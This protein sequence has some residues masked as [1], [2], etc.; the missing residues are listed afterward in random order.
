[1]EP[2]S[3]RVE[4]ST[5]GSKLESIFQPI[6]ASMPTL[7]VSDDDDH[8]DDDDDDDDNVIDNDYL[9]D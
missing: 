2:L 3:G 9:I 8:D 7:V 4:W 1:M 6:F 5:W